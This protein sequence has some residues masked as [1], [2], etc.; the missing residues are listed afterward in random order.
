MLADQQ[1]STY[2]D[3]ELP[4]DQA[5]LADPE[6]YLAGYEGTLV[7]LDEIH[8]TP[9][10]FQVL[11]GVID[12]RRRKGIK[13]GQFLALGSASMDLLRQSAETLAGR[14]SY[15][16]LTPFTVTEVA[17]DDVSTADRL[18]V[19]G[20]FPESF[21]ADNDAASLE[22]RRA[23]IQTY[24]ER[25]IPLLGPR[26]PSETLHRFWQM[27]AHAQGQLFHAAPLASGLGA[28]GH[29]VARY[30]AILADLLLVRRLQPWSGNLKKRLVRSPKVYVR[31]SGLVHALL[32]IR[33]REELLGH[34]VAGPSWEGW[35][36]E[37]LLSQGAPHATAW[38]YR[39]SA[40]AEIDLLLEFAAGDRH[41][42]E[43]KRSLNDPRPSKGFHLACDDL[44]VRGRWVV[45]PGRERYRLDARTE[46]VP[47]TEATR[48]DF[49][50]TTKPQ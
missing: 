48:P 38:F 8:R 25:D 3:L 42:V 19:R 10:I 34:P 7:I 21:L 39:S 37:N 24:L 46:V 17:N 40:G 6:L 49:N 45:Y 11:R 4:S 23:F 12:A 22:W 47:F 26:I 18:W 20:G 44:Q 29:T 41:A 15:L 35:V 9:G 50:W 36:I 16:E 32:G 2:L 13:A 14:I 27:L 1:R 31:D 33:D 43:I 30:L 28:S 5:K